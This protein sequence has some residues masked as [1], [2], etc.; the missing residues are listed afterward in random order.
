MSDADLCRGWT[1][2]DVREMMIKVSE[3]GKDVLAEIAATPGTTTPEIAENLGLDSWRNVRG[4]LSALGR[5][6]NSMGVNDPATGHP[7]WPF[8][9]RRGRRYWRYYMPP[10]VAQI[11]LESPAGTLSRLARRRLRRQVEIADDRT[12][13]AQAP[14]RVKRLVD[15]ARRN[16]VRQSAS[17]E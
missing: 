11:V 2:A 5:V 6:T 1:A 13:V 17:C 4:I 3:P 9:F 7:S 15:P 16:G 12:M 14:V 8:R 10:E